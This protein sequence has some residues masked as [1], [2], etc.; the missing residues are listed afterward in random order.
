MKTEN[1]NAW[2]SETT[3]GMACSWLT[4]FCASFSADN[5][6]VVNL[7]EN[8]HQLI[9]RLPPEW[10]NADGWLAGWLLEDLVQPSSSPSSL[11]QP[12]SVPNN[13]L[14]ESRRKLK[15]QLS[16]RIQQQC[17]KCLFLAHFLAWYCWSFEDYADARPGSCKRIV[18]T[19]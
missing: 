10:L 9:R 2:K 1:K 13:G 4:F 14:L 18:M 16:R 11:W 19:C 5:D 6:I 3:F 15:I 12:G 17:N 7:I 8:L